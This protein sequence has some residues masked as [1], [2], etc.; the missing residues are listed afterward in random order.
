MKKN[1][2]GMGL[3]SGKT[4]ALHAKPNEKVEAATSSCSAAV[5]FYNIFIPCVWL[6]IIRRADKEDPFRS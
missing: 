4:E 3:L 2:G 5:N 1:V 6:R